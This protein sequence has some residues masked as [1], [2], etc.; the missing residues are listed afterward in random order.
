MSIY[1]NE[2]GVDR[3]CHEPVGVE[4]RV[5]CHY[6]YMV[7]RRHRSGAHKSITVVTHAVKKQDS[8]VKHHRPIN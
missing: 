6:I 5:R 4:S 2:G 7:M 8:F 1:G 3:P